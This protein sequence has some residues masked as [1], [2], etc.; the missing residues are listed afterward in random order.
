M[1][2]RKSYFKISKLRIVT[3]DL[4]IDILTLRNIKDI[5]INMDILDI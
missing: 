2:A 1:G 3:H 4:I 5:Q